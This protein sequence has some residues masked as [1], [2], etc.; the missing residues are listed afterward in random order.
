MK[1][2]LVVLMIGLSS[3]VSAVELRTQEDVCEYVVTGYIDRSVENA[4]RTYTLSKI[5]YFH[6]EVEMILNR[7]GF[8]NTDRYMA[9]LRTLE[10]TSLELFNE[11]PTQIKEDYLERC[12]KLVVVR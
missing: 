11:R 8:I 12:M 9:T 10:G 1:R 7:F 2:L 3:S 4:K 5:P 6:K